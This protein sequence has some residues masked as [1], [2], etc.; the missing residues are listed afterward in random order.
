MAV[1]AFIYANVFERAFAAEM[2]FLGENMAVLLT[3]TTPYVP[4]QDTHEDGADVTD[5]VAEANGYLQGQDGSGELL[6]SKVHTNT[7]NV[8][9]F[10]IAD[11]QWT[12]TGAGFS[13]RI[14][15]FLDT[16]TGVASTN[17]LFSWMDFGQTESASG[18]GTF[19]IAMAAAP[20]LAT[21]TAAD[22]SGFP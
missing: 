17:P 13:S 9:G 7:L 5:E 8:S 12:A 19:T 16:S 6:L 11:P 18:G 15:V 21:M 3:D 2:D 4:N 1:T 10:D 22:A 14:A 20:G